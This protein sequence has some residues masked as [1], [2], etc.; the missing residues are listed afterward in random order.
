M[1]SADGSH[2]LIEIAHGGMGGLCPDTGP[3]MNTAPPV[4][5]TTSVR[6]R[7]VYLRL[8][9]LIGNNAVAVL[10]VVHIR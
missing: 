7:R 1:F 4:S 8:Q 3:L 10:C 9:S 6:A 2:S 5:K